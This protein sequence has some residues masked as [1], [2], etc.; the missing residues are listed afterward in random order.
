[1]E[2]LTI[3]AGF[4]LNGI[5]FLRSVGQVTKIIELCSSDSVGMD[6]FSTSECT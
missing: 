3:I 2:L 5:K 4:S 1:M 6:G